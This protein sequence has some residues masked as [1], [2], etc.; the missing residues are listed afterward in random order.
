MI[1]TTPKEHSTPQPAVDSQYDVI[2][3]GGGPA[4]S[5]VA[6][7]VSQAGYRTLLL[8]RSEAPRFHVGE[9]LVPETYWS[10]KRLG[11]LEQLKQSAFPK[12]YSVQFVT[13]QGKESQPFYFDQYKDH[14]SSQTWQVIR[15]EFDAMLLENAKTNHV[16]VRTDASALDV[17]FEDQ[18][19]TGVKVRFQTEAEADH[20]T[21][22]LNCKIVVD[23][24]G[25]SA[26]LMNRLGLKIADPH[27]KQGSIWTY[28]QDAYRDEGKDEGA[29]I[30]L[31]TEGKQSWFWYIPLPDN[32]V[33]VGCTG[34]LDY[35]FGSQKGTH[36]EIFMR[37]VER[38]PGMKRRLATGE[39]VTNFFT[40]KDFSYRTKQA[41][42]PGWVL[43]GD[44]C[45]F[46]DP[47]YSTGVLLAFKS[48][49]MV[50]DAIVAALQE[51]NLTQEKLGAWY[52]EYAAGVELFR[53]LVYAFYAPG[54][55]FGSFLKMHPQYRSNLIDLLIGD[56]FKEGVG[57]IFDVI[58]DLTPA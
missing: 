22:I 48:G 27:L 44:A 11:V 30:I 57:E 3:I 58:G 19:A 37:E 9:S 32:Q 36:E 4:G 21:R 55:S 43:A 17:V 20:T 2:V 28:F 16:V 40:T 45:G 23:A 34:R 46:I 54:F 33:S 51:E 1:E 7:L 53:K 13:E 5:T 15:S 14:E 56:A 26:F 25:Q 38:C 24:S 39:R 49:E 6:T 50:A 31:Q 29:T 52:P 35:L 10:L 18:V 42:G 41:S 47:V 12:K 8:E